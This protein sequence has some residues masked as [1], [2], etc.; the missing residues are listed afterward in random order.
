[1]AAKLCANCGQ[2]EARFNRIVTKT[3]KK[4]RRFRSDKHHDLCPVCWRAAMSAAREAT[5]DGAFP[6]GG[7][8]QPTHDRSLSARRPSL[9]D[10]DGAVAE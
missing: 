7:P 2:R 5:P 1:M 4:F 9:D 10:Y 3:A 8:I 6:F